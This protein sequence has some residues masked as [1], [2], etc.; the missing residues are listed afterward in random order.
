[1]ALL[2]GGA[3]DLV[4]PHNW[5]YNITYSLPY[6]PYHE[7]PCAKKL[8]WELARTSLEGYRELHRASRGLRGFCEVSMQGLWTRVCAEFIA[9]D[10]AGWNFYAEKIS[11]KRPCRAQEL[12]QGIRS[13]CSFF[14][15]EI[16]KETS[17]IALN[18]ASPPCF[19][20]HGQAPCRLASP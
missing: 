17:W 4:T 10:R 11:G 9:L 6:W 13:S 5:A 12:W 18:F 3:W 8:I 14:F 1:M 16:H 20:C 19:R 15:F 7:P 2:L